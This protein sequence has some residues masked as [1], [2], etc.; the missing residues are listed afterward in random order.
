MSEPSA[1]DISEFLAALAGRDPSDR[2]G[3]ADLMTR[4]ADLLERI[5]A[6]R[7]GDV[8]AAEVA[9]N[10]RARAEQLTSTDR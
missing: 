8:D 1:A 2:D 9:A 10:A 5:A 7:P 3:Y 4:K 6:A